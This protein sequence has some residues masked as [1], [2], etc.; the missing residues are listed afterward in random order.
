MKFKNI[1]LLSGLFILLTLQLTGC[2]QTPT[3]STNENT[4]PK[5]PEVVNIAF[6]DI[7][8]D[9]IV[10]KIKGWYETELGVKV[11]FKKFDSGR[12]INN[13]FAS[14]SIDFA[15]MGSTPA[16]V[17][18]SKGLGYEV[19]WI[20]DVIGVAESLAVRNN[21]NINSLQDLKGKKVAVPFS[22]TAHY[23]LLS[24]LKLEGINASEVIILDMQPPDILAAWQRGDID[25]AYV[26]NPVLGKLLENGKTTFFKDMTMAF[27]RLI[28]RRDKI[29]NDNDEKQALVMQEIKA[30]K[31]QIK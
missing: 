15:L 3:A 23:S 22:S 17:G 9:E 2:G 20:H 21:A 7:P 19:F 5:K 4:A 18:I 8:N 6:Q 11:N 26:W 12:D 31:N 30:K 29:N 16:S 10:A 1:L 24:A 14:K 13:A 25:A 28:E 27:D